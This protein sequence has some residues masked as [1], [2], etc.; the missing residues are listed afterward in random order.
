MHFGGKGRKRRSTEGENLAAT[1][2]E[3]SSKK[4]RN[5][6]HERQLRWRSG[7]VRREGVLGAKKGGT[8]FDT[9]VWLPE[10]NYFRTLGGGTRRFVN[11]GC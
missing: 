2:P 3:G 9:A 1:R 5:V 11:I 8:V 4:C 10:R 7:D 6:L